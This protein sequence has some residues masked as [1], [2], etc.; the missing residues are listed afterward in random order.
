MTLCFPRK[1]LCG[2]KHRECDYMYTSMLTKDYLDK[3]KNQIPRNQ[4]W[5]SEA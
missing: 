4:L 5:F 1:V 2:A 3:P